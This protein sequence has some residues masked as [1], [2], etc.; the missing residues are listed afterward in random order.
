MQM[1][2]ALIGSHPESADAHLHPYV[3]EFEYA[4]RYHPSRNPYCEARWF[5]RES[6]ERQLERMVRR[7]SS[8]E[9]PPVPQRDRPWIEIKALLVRDSKARKGM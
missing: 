6:H 4:P 2:V 1:V 7:R 9:E 5:E 8:L 3:S